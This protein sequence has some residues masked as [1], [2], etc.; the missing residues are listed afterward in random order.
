MKYRAHYQEGNR[1]YSSVIDGESP[2]MVRAKFAQAYPGST[3]KRL[4]P[5]DPAPSA[6]AAAPKA[7]TRGPKRMPWEHSGE[8]RTP[9]AEAA[10]LAREACRLKEELK[11]QLEGQS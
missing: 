7:A 2:A 6:P 10:R 9:D 4:V 11:R 8:Q 5:I 1:E 3:I